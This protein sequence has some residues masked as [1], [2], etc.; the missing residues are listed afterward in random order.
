VFDLQDGIGAVFDH[1]RDGV[2]VGRAEYEGLEDQ[3]VQGALE[4]IRL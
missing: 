2:A 4:Q 1:V 3:Q